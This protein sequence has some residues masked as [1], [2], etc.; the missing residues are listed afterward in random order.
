MFCMCTDFFAQL[1]ATSDL[2]ENVLRETI[3]TYMS[4]GGFITLTVAS[5]KLKVNAVQ[6]GTF[7]MHLHLCSQRKHHT[8]TC[9]QN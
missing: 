1:F 6:F 7:G 2:L 9:W 4:I 8:K 5:I 3:Y